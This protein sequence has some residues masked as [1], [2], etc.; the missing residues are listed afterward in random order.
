MINVHVTADQILIFG[1]QEI[2]DSYE[3]IRKGYGHIVVSFDKLFDISSENIYYLTFYN[4]DLRTFNLYMKPKYISLYHCKTSSTFYDIFNATTA[5]KIFSNCCDVD[6]SVPD[7]VSKMCKVDLTHNYCITMLIKYYDG[8][9][10]TFSL[11]RN[12]TTKL[13]LELIKKHF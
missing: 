1:P 6:Y 8:D 5:F 11:K 10:K 13:N 2:L 7:Y 3:H 4:M 12:K 9:V